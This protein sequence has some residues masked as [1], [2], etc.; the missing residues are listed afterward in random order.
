MTFNSANHLAFISPEFLHTCLDHS[1]VRM[2]VGLRAIIERTWF[3]A[4][5]ELRAIYIFFH[6]EKILKVFPSPSPP[7]QKNLQH[8]ENRYTVQ[9]FWDKCHTFLHYSHQWEVALLQAICPVRLLSAFWLFQ[10]NIRKLFVW[11]LVGIRNFL[12]LD[13]HL[14][15]TSILKQSWKSQSWSKYCMS[16][17][18]CI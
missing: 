11:L 5:C 10:L 2:R 14:C 6:R 17:D 7:P 12:P 8:F 9:I 3:W 4:S 18:I 13:A 1:F 15:H 16:L